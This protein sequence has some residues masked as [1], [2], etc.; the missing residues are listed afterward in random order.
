MKL[1]ACDAAETED[2]TNCSHGADARSACKVLA[3]VFLEPFI[4]LFSDLV[5]RFSCLIASMFLI[6]ARFEV[7]IY[8]I[9]W[10]A[11]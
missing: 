2:C 4:E 1:I 3:Y 10:F 11:L 6:G 5:V 9:S 8:F 7:R